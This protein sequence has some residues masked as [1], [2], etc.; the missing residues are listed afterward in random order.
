LVTGHIHAVLPQLADATH[1][2]PT[3][4]W[5]AGAIISTVDDLLVYG[6]ARIRSKA[7]SSARTGGDITRLRPND[8]PSAGEYLISIPT[9]PSGMQLH[10]DGRYLPW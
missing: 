6:Q 7:T 8:C 3:W 1:W 5:T 2:S 4:S 10:P 9:I